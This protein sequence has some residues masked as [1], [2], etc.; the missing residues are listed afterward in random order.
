M[1]YFVESSA[2]VKAYLAERGSAWVAALVDP[3]AGNTAHVARITA[4]EV[5]AAIARRRRA[6]GIGADEA[7]RM[8]AALRTAFRDD[9]AV[10]AVT[11]SLLDHA[12]FL[13]DVQALRGYDA[14]Q[15]AAALTVNAE[16]VALKL[17]PLVLV[18]ADDEL[19]AAAQVEGL[20]V[21]DPNAHP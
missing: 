10:A 4:V 15:L 1:V 21:E 17:P 18:S 19:N 11:E 2:L 7:Q 16:R 13:S 5:V 12:M 3:D 14:V 6:G 9:F 8:L 20:A